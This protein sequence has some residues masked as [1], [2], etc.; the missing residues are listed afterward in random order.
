[1]RLILLI[2]TLMV[3]SEAANLNEVNKEEWKQFKVSV[4]LPKIIR[5]LC[6]VRTNIFIVAVLHLCGSCS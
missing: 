6:L 5:N 3:L 2:S 4:E 1:M